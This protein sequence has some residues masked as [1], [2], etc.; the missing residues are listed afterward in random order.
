M[1]QNFHPYPTEVGKYV[2]EKD[3][4]VHVWDSP[5]LETTQML[6]PSGMPK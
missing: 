1:T 4:N 5:N 3:K 2:Q 6:I